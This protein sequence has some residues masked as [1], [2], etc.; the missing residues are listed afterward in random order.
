M[1]TFSACQKIVIFGPFFIVFAIYL[2]QI[3]FKANFFWYGLSFLIISRNLQNPD[4][5]PSRNSWAVLNWISENF[6]NDLIYIK[7][8]QPL[9]FFFR[10][11][12]PRGHWRLRPCLKNTQIIITPWTW[13]LLHTGFTQPRPRPSYLMIKHVST[14]LWRWRNSDLTRKVSRTRS[15]GWSRDP[16]G[17]KQ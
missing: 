14:R 4:Q 10:G 11:Y 7:N 1:R 15:T 8:V 16:S 5:N 2:K 12:Y 9:L 3:V 6:E 17:S 13:Y